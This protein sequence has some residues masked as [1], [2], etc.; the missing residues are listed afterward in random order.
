MIS[1]FLLYRFKHS[2]KPAA[3]AP[4]IPLTFLVAYQ[5]DFA[6]GNKIDRIQGKRNKLISSQPNDSAICIHYEGCMYC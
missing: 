6:Y 5:Y 2:R 4:L 3:I 1:A